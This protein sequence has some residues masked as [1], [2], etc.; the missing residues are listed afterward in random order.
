MSVFYKNKPVTVWRIEQGQPQPDWVKQCFENNSMIWYD[1]KLKILVKV[2]NPS[3]KRDT[4]LGLLDTF[5]GY[6]GGGFVMGT[7]GDFF[8]ATNGRLV[9][10]KKFYKQYVMK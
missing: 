10:K 7:V 4:K 3:A 6:Y 9:S 8:D 5:L 1:N 2:I